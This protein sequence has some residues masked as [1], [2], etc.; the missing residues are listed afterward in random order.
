MRVEGP[1][2]EAF[3]N[4]ICDN[5]LSV[6]IGKIVYTQFLNHA[7]GIEAD[8][9]VTR[10]SETAFMVITPAVTR[11]ADETWMRRH[12]DDRDVVITDVTAGEVVMAAVR[13]QARQLLQTVSPNAF[14]NKA[15][16][17]GTMQ[18]MEIVLAL[19]H[20]HRVSSAA[21]KAFDL[22]PC[23]MHAMNCGRIEKG[24]RHFGYYIT[25][26]DNVLEVGLRFA[27]KTRKPEFI[28]RDAVLHKEEAGLNTRPLQFQ[29]QDP[30]P[31][32][33]H[34]ESVLRDSETVGCLS[35]GAYGNRL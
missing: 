23:G 35:S 2:T 33:Y 5:D 15:N 14:S 30:D 11:L 25:Q 9:I 20:A 4:Y 18:E 34:N 3:L 12:L 26:E 21:G 27:V 10:L 24:F 29:L 7:G 17:F 32:F 31:M 28:G 8:V 22:K 13:P 1:D 16:P 6:P 19:A